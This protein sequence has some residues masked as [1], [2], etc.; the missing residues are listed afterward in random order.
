MITLYKQL[1]GMASMT[2][3]DAKIEEQ[4]GFSIPDED[5]Q[6]LT[7]IYESNDLDEREALLAEKL[8]FHEQA[9]YLFL[10]VQQKHDRPAPTEHDNDPSL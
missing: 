5:R 10:R 6:L 1:Y 8:G 7:K 3:M 9:M 4:L 2:A